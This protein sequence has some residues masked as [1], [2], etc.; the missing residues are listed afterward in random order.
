MEA[1][2]TYFMSE[3][4]ALGE[5]ILAAFEANYSLSIYLNIR[6]PLLAVITRISWPGIC[7]VLT[8]SLSDLDCF[9]RPQGYN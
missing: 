2:T 6:V 4:N 1:I 9:A 5:V 3:R 7:Q 8:D